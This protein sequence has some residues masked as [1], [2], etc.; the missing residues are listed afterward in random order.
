MDLSIICVNWNSVDYLLECISSIYEWTR[1][2]SFEVIVV[3]NASPAKNVDMLS[4]HFSEIKIIKSQKNLGFA[5]ANNLGFRNSK[6]D[7]VLFLNPDTK[8]TQPAITR[9]L[10]DFRSLPD[11]GIMG[12]KLLNGDLS[13]QT[14]SIMKFPRILN[15]TFH[16]ERLRVRWPG[17][18]GIGPLFSSKQ[19]P[20]SVE[21]ISGACML[22]TRQVFESVGMFNERYFMYSEDLDLCYKVKRAGLNNYYVGSIAI[23]HY[24]GRSSPR[25]SQTAMKT[26]A[27][28]QFCREHYGTFY[29]LLYR[30]A[31]LCNASV[32]LLLLASWRF[33]ARLTGSRMT[34]ESTWNRWRVM[35][36]T[37]IGI[38]H[39]SASC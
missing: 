29:A 28:L 36:K 31:L 16:V 4:E 9:M 38:R 15:T 11:V 33:L 8:L 26:R 35:F 21:A 18:W 6:G 23:I 10:R 7:Y 39:M 25:A 12:C 3:D 30:V 24:G 1:G 2:I 14:S 22:T 13:V 32:R 19:D 34:T 37:L 5:G 17:I 20:V 27:E